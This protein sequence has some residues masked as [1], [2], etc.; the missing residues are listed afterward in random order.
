MILTPAHW[1]RCWQ[2]IP[3]P[4]SYRQ[5]LAPWGRTSAGHAGSQELAPAAGT[6]ACTARR[7]GRSS[8]AV[9]SVRGKRGHKS[10]NVP[11]ADNGKSECRAVSVGYWWDGPAWIKGAEGQPVVQCHLWREKGDKSAA[12]T[13]CWEYTSCAVPSVTSSA[14][15]SVKKK[16]EIN[17]ANWFLSEWQN[18][19]QIPPVNAKPYGGQVKGLQWVRWGL[20]FSAELS[21]LLWICLSIHVHPE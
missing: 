11:C 4:Q 20:R 15:P 18:Q 1:P 5:R 10:A 17:E 19:A 12:I 8:N 14:T 16:E 3:P 6:C 13:G 7:W 2:G 9:Q 21:T